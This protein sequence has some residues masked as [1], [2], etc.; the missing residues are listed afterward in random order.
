MDQ[1]SFVSDWRLTRKKRKNVLVKRA[2][3]IG[4]GLARSGDLAREIGAEIGVVEGRALLRLHSTPQRRF[5]THVAIA[6][7]VSTERNRNIRLMVLRFGSL[8]RDDAIG[9]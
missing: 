2:T 7:L 9:L 3:V 8:E 4:I 1:L 6:F 5:R